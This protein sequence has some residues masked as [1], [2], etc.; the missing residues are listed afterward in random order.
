VAPRI[1]GL[2]R[3]L[4]GFLGEALVAPVDRGEKLRGIAGIGGCL[5]VLRLDPLAPDDDG[6]FTPRLAQDARQGGFHG[7][8]GVRLVEVEKGFVAELGN[9]DRVL[10]CK[11]WMLRMKR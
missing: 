1:E 6:D 7:P 11:G 3:G 8:A 5:L 10:F 2:R 4:Q 9:Q